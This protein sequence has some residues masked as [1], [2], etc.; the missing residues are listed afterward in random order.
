MDDSASLDFVSKYYT[1]CAH[2]VADEYPF[3][4][5]PPIRYNSY[6]GGSSAAAATPSRPVSP[7][8]AVTLYFGTKKAPVSSYYGY[9]ARAT[10]ALFGEPWLLNVSKVS[11]QKKRN[12]AAFK[13]AISF[14]AFFFFSLSF[15]STLFTI[16][17]M[18]SSGTPPSSS[19]L[20]HQLNLSS[21]FAPLYVPPS[22][23]TLAPQSSCIK[24]W[25]LRWTSQMR[26]TSRR[27]CGW[28]QRRA[29]AVAAGRARA[30]RGQQ[31]KPRGCSLFTSA[32]TPTAGESKLWSVLCSLKGGGG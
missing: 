22:C 2:E 8:A 19:S 9:N 13:K 15:S 21:F 14:D 23:R 5:T 30:R 18:P 26:S 27:S 29:R 10:W 7:L 25:R 31:Q 28:R 12:D 17:K 4:Y 3:S 24:R 16:S 11:T 1:L 6:W 20:L 32:T